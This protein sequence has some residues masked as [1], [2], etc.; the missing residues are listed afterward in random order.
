[1]GVVGALPDDLA[2]SLQASVK[3]SE[4]SNPAIKQYF[5]SG[6]RIDGV[7]IMHLDHLRVS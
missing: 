4:P 6:K 7:A 2:S 3:A 1:M 5:A